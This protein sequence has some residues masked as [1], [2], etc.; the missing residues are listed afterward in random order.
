MT[1]KKQKDPETMMNFVLTS[2]EAEDMELAGMVRPLPAAIR[3]STN[4]VQTFR[5]QLVEA[6]AASRERRAA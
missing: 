5:A 1:K 6:M 2:D 4:F 3:P